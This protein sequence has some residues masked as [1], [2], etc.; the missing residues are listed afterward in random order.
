[1]KNI[2][3]TGATGFMGRNLVEKL[4][5]M[6]YQVSGVDKSGGMIGDTSIDALDCTNQEALNRYCQGKSF[7]GIIHLAAS[8][9][10]SFHGEEARQSLLEN[11][12]MTINL[13]E[14]AREQ[15]GK[16]FI[17]ASGTSVYGYPDKLPVTE[18]TPAQPDGFYLLGKFFGELLCQQYQKEYKLPVAILRISAPYGPGMRKETVIRKFIKQALLSEDITLYGTGSRSQDF[19]Y[20]EDV[21]GAIVQAYEAK[22]TGIFNV[23]SGV[24][25][26]MKELAETILRVLPSSKSRIVYSGAKDPQEGYRAAFSFEKARGSFGYQP[27]FPLTRGIEEYARAIKEELGL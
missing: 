24:S 20:I 22:A 1:M 25:T 9:P 4:H 15:G 7:D 13:L 23:S 5:S 19:T 16:V 8:V 11:V 17:Y 14:V 27:K 2:L 3:V 10:P 18:E 6:A 12:Q 26:S 21:T